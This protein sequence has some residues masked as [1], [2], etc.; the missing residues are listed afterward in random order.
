MIDIPASFRS[1]AKIKAARELA[2]AEKSGASEHRKK[3]II[4]NIS[5]QEWKLDRIEWQ[6]WMDTMRGKFARIHTTPQ[7]RVKITLATYRKKP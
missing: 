1:A 2:I 4:Q 3:M 7:E 5:E 6:D